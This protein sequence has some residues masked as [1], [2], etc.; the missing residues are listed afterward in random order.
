MCCICEI[1]NTSLRNA[2]ISSRYNVLLICVR[3]RWIHHLD[4]DK[5]LSQD[6]KVTPQF[7]CPCGKCTVSWSPWTDVKPARFGSTP[8]D[9]IRS[10]PKGLFYLANP[11]E[12]GFCSV[13]TISFW[14]CLDS[15]KWSQSRTNVLLGSMC[16]RLDD[17]LTTDVH[18]FPEVG[19]RIV[20]SKFGPHK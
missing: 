6:R 13:W 5:Y 9:F 17:C 16:V 18:T 10:S 20:F 19:C 15:T 14:P 1:Q 12:Q 2:Y 3:H 8:L 11:G 7:N 4:I